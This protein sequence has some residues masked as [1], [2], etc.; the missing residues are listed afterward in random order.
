MSARVSEDSRTSSLLGTAYL[1]LAVIA[2]MKAM[3]ENPE[4]HVLVKLQLTTPS[5]YVQGSINLSV[6]LI[7]NWTLLIPFF[8]VADLH[9]VSILPLL[10]TW[11]ISYGVGANP[12][13]S[14]SLHSCLCDL[15]G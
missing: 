1:P 11:C 14:S 7:G 12:V 13:L 5:G 6:S 15:G 3:K 2:R 9:G 10:D 8:L 4:D